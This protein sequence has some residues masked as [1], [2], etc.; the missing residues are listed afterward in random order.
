MKNPDYVVAISQCKN[1]DPKKS[2][3]E[4]LELLK[5]GAEYIFINVEIEI[6][7]EILHIKTK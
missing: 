1:T 3:Q 5:K 6:G 4:V 7:E 2:S